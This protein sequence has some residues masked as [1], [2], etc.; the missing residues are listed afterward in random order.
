[1]VTSIHDL[2]ERAT[3]AAQT[4]PP[5]VDAEHAETR[6]T[7]LGHAGRALLALADESIRVESGRLAKRRLIT[8]ELAAACRD[9]AALWPP[10]PAPAVDLAA[11]AADL[12]AV[13]APGLDRDQR[14]AGAMALADLARDCAAAAR[15]FPPY[16]R[17]PGL[18]RVMRVSTM[19]TAA[20]AIDSPAPRAWAWLDRPV[21]AGRVAANAS[22]PDRVLECVAS[23]V[24]ELGHELRDGRLNVY[25][26]LASSA[27][28]EDCAR[29]AEV[30][31]RVLG[32]PQPY[33]HKRA[34]AAQSWQVL[35]AAL[36]RF[37]DGSR[38]SAA[39]RSAVPG[40]ALSLHESPSAMLLVPDRG[41]LDEVATAARFVANQLPA[42]AET[43]EDAVL[44]AAQDG[45]LV[46]RARSLGTSDEH[47]IAK[48]H[49]QP[50]VVTPR[51]VGP[52]LHTARV[53]ARLSASLAVELDRSSNTIGR[54]PQPYL[55][56][57][58]G[59][60][61]RPD[62]LARDAVWTRRLADRCVAV[63][64]TPALEL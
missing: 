53:T 51:D 24:D 1:M 22:P 11:A 54:Q 19:L 40:L 27:A 12:T 63:Q 20:A 36:I 43:V 13:T 26:A 8:A 23:L 29:R 48:I 64:H 21:P 31:L 5:E 42:V 34:P 49:D 28:A 33:D 7:A 55:V 41:N 38:H 46:A 18:A 57:A 44:R 37:D 47:I 6:A 32:R 59:D 14:W 50:V 39:A 25:S 16:A 45:R 17:V 58:L 61:L 15:S 35:Q 3:L 62:E 10:R 52:V 60:G 56:R 30:V 2:V 9:A 4:A